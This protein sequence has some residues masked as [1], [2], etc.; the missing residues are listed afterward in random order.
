MDVANKIDTDTIEKD[1]I[2][3]L[4]ESCDFNELAKIRKLKLAGKQ[5][6]ILKLLEE[7]EKELKN[8]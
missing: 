7:K 5:E 2:F 4:L 6:E 3:K 8:E 1:R